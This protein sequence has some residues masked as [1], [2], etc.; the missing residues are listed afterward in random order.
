MKKTESS[1]LLL[2]FNYSKIIF[3]IGPPA[4]K[5]IK[6]K[7]KKADLEVIMFNNWLPFTMGDFYSF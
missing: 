6:A 5:V 2:N 3:G 1:L 4:E 7:A